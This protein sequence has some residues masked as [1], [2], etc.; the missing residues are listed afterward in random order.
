M[1][2]LN[3]LLSSG[4][5]ASFQFPVSDEKEKTLVRELQIAES[6]PDAL[7]NSLMVGTIGSGTGEDKVSVNFQDLYKSLSITAKAV[8]D[9]I[10]EQLG[11]FLPNGVQSLKP[12]DVTPE[13]TADRIVAGTTA[14]FDAYAKQHK[15][16]EGEELIDS[17][18]AEIRKGIGTGY[19]DAV[20]IL[21]G[22]G[23][24]NYDGV[25]DGI[26]KTKSLI[27]EKLIAFENLKRKELGLPV[28]ESSKDEAASKT[29]NEVAAQA[30]ASI[31]FSA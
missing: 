12:E 21:E 26:E 20:N 31:N 14:F 16:L 3:G 5:A 28:A 15:N 13:A 24:F 25:K 29:K 19:D 30:G 1:D 8:V 23:A 11:E 10:N 18:M 17:F 22:L 6:A 2:S 27:E 7:V 9:K 4:S